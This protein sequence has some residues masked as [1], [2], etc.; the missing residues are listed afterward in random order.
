MLIKILKQLSKMQKITTD[1]IATS[2]NLRFSIAI[3]QK[4]SIKSQL[5]SIFIDNNIIEY[6]IQQLE[7]H[8]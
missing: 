8:Y 4:I 7:E 2:V 1:P 3:M 5:S 6:V